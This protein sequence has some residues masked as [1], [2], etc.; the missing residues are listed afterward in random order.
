M[1]T[2]RLKF[3]LR[4]L[5]AASHFSAVDTRVDSPETHGRREA[6]KPEP[7]HP[8]GSRVHHGKAPPV[9][10]ITGKHL[11]IHFDECLPSLGRAHDWNDWTKE[12]LLLQ[13][14]GHRRARVLQ[15]W[16]IL[17]TDTKKSY[18]QSVDAL[19]RR[20]NPGSRTLAAQDFR[21]TLQA[22]EERAANFIQ[23]LQRTFNIAY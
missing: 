5:S 17:E 2:E 12:E 20:L 9:D 8:A 21:H 11:E 16:G 10:S 6:H 18:T 22:E 4:S 23:R 7:V 3:Q 19:H 14:A 13:L 15:E 1:E